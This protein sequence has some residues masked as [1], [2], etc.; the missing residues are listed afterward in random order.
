MTNSHNNYL[1]R[2]N[3][4]TSESKVSKGWSIINVWSINNFLESKDLTT[5]E[6]RMMEMESG[7]VSEGNVAHFCEQISSY[8][9]K[10]QTF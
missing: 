3:W 9:S 7:L 2:A 10:F 8:L 4:E 6:K 5:L 1:A